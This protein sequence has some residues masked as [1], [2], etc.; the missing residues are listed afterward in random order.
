MGLALF[1][2]AVYCSVKF[3]DATLKTAYG[4]SLVRAQAIMPSATKHCWIYP[5]TRST[6]SLMMPPAGLEAKTLAMWISRYPPLPDGCLL[7]LLCT[8][9]CRGI[10]SQCLGV[11]Q[12]FMYEYAD[13]TPI[14]RNPSEATDSGFE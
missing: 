2:T 6:C 9:V 13:S 8:I 10:R 7:D 3:G 12:L 1:T 14:C 5:S 4:S 11:Y